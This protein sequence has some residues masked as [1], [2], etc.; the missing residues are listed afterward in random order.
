MSSG[1]FSRSEAKTGGFILLE[2]IVV[3]VLMTVIVGFSLIFWANSLPTHRFNA[4]VRDI[5]SS[6]KQ[7]RALARIHSRPEAV[8]FNLEGRTYGVE[9]H[10]QR[11]LPADVSV[12][13]KDPVEGEIAEGEYR[14]LL[15][16]TGGFEGGTIVVRSEKRQA[17]IEMDPVAG[18]LMIKEDEG[19]F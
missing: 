15:F 16:P 7:A 10:K 14:F 5:G 8:A 18:T 13:I 6:I 3:L 12:I 19:R 2:L 17:S 1:F 4:A 11:E 9:G